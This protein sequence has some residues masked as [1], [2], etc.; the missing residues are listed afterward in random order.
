MVN[1]LD[2]LA[3]YLNLTFIIG[4]NNRLDTKLHEKRDDFNFHII[5]FP[6]LSS[7]T[8]SG[9]QY[10]VYIWQLALKEDQPLRVI[11]D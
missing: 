6:F 11:Y 3:N 4:N 1:R 7:N 5:N 10:G 2:D 8:L 9:P